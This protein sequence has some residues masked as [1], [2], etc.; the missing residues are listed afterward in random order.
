MTAIIRPEE[1]SNYAAI[2][3]INELAF[4][5]PAEGRLVDALRARPDYIRGLSL[6]A[7]LEKQIV[8]HI[9]FSPI[10]ILSPE[11][12]E[13]SALALAPMAVLPDYQNLG[14]GTQLVRNGLERCE[15]MGYNT[16]VVLGH[17]TY[18]PKFGFERASNYG[19]YCPFEVPDE[20]FMVWSPDASLLKK[21]QGTVVYP[22]E[23]NEVG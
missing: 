13:L 10:K 18:Y 7:Q 15:R 9:L 1:H 6:V 17:P 14:I 4:K 5:N 8:G 23:F 11:G 21:V 3:K 12:K 2:R 22:E 19:I 20:A 16:V